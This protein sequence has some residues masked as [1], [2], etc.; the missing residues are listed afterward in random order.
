MQIQECLINTDVRMEVIKGEGHLLIHL[1][2][3]KDVAM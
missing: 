2:E 1:R 3:P